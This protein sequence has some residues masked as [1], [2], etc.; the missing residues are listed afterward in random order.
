MFNKGI[1][2]GLCRRAFLGARQL[3]FW[4]TLEIQGENKQFK[5][6]LRIENFRHCLFQSTVMTFEPL[7]LPNKKLSYGQQR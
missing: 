1:F 5:K 3:I 4:C 7:T 6:K 2:T